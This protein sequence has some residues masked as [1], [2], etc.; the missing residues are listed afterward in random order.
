MMD[1]FEDLKIAPAL[2]AGVEM[3]GWD[4]PS[5]LQR[6]ATAVIRRGNNVILHASA[7]SGAVGAYGL[8]ILDRLIEGDETPGDPAILVLVTDTHT[9][10]ATAES[11]ARLAAPAEIAVRAL[12]PGWE[13]ER[14]VLV[15]TPAAALAG[16]RASTL[17]LGDLSSLVIQDADLLA[18]TDQ[19]DD[20]ETLIDTAPAAA[21]RIVVTG[22]LTP[23]IEGFI[24]RHVR[25]A[26]TVPPRA[27][28]EEPRADAPVIRYAVVPES[29]K[30]AAAA[31]FL[32][33]MGKD[34]AAVV[35]RSVDR[36]AEVKQVLGAR[37]ITDG[38][39]R[40]ILVLPRQ[41]ADQRS[42]QA[43]VLSYDTPFDSA[44]LEALHSGG[45]TVLVTPR[46][47]AHLLRIARRAGL[48]TEAVATPLAPIT[49]V[50]EL[51]DRLRQLV[52]QDLTP[53][54]ALLEPLLAEIPAAEIAA[55]AIRLGRA[56]EPAATRTVG[57]TA[58]A[59]S[60]P[61]RAGAPPPDAGTWVHLFM[62]IGSRDDVGPG[63]IVG[64]ITGEA[65]VSGD[66]V[67][68]IDIRES[69]TTVEVATGVAPRVIEALNGRSVK[70]RSLRVDYDRKD[71]EPRGGRKPGHG[72]SGRGAGG[73][74]SRRPDSRRRG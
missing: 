35:C 58:P 69:H 45:G 47:R 14:T 53:E 54:L 74:G 15:A 19:W 72:T 57:S 3:L 55:A 73:P 38:D 30:P 60:T 48:R 41:E 51:R 10:T 37:G 1:T 16:V 70:G 39:D 7:G 42:V 22:K 5:G 33:G 6:D 2:M 62:T 71:R 64:A 56:A 23:A 17:K 40:Q 52:A 24:D 63:D 11:L 67:G 29:G 65:G 61:G 66:K 50:D 31:H 21:Q 49:A 59:A 18:G 4:A 9:T 28:V 44:E 25:K 8:G 20:V 43:D 26:M 36:A 12:A 32:S 46:E 34:Q 68:K 27:E 13:G